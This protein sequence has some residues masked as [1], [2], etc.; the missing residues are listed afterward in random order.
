MKARDTQTNETV[1]LTKTG[2]VLRCIQGGG[3]TTPRSAHRHLFLVDAK[4]KPNN[5]P[6]VGWTGFKHF[7][8]TKW[9]DWFSKGL[10]IKL[11]PFEYYDETR[12]AHPQ[13]PHEDRYGTV[14]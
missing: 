1:W 10:Y 5:R 8:Y 4:A 3:E 13:P 14:S 12:Y 2:T 11:G 6:G 9:N 7:G